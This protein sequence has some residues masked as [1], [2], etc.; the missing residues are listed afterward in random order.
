[1]FLPAFTW[2]KKP[3]T[4][5]W[6]P[7]QG[8]V[9]IIIIYAVVAFSGLYPTSSTPEHVSVVVQKSAEVFPVDSRSKS[10]KEQNGGVNQV[11]NSFWIAALSGRYRL[12][13]FLAAIPCSI[14]LASF[15]M[16]EATPPS[17]RSHRKMF[18]CLS[19]TG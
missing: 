7:S 3:D 6:I 9:A 8:K 12:R 17:S 5:P 1:M 10:W 2:Q 15:A 13:A 16:S 4:R 18:Y 14:A 19:A 11:R